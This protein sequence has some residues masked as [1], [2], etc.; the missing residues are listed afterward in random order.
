LL[1]ETGQQVAGA[2]RVLIRV[3]T[4]EITASATSKP[5]ASLCATDDRCRSAEGED[6]RNRV[7]SSTAS[8]SDATRWYD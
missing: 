8:A 2:R 3:A 5:N 4:S 7:A 1:P 6:E